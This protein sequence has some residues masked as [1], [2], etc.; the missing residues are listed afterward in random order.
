MKLRP[1]AGNDCNFREN[2]LLVDGKALVENP[3]EEMKKVQDFLEINQSLTEKN[4]IKE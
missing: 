1:K 4:F 2:I 3:A